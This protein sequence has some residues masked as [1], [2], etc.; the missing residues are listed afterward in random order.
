[1][2]SIGPQLPPHL[3]KRKRS[4]DE[5]SDSDS[6]TDTT[7]RPRAIGPYPRPAPSTGPDDVPLS[8]KRPDPAPPAQDQEEEESSS[9]DDDV[10]PALPP[11]TTSSTANAPHANPQGLQPPPTQSKEPPKREAWMTM[12][13]TSGDWA[14]RPPDPTKLKARKFNSTKPR[15]RGAAAGS[16]TGGEGSWNETP[17]EKAERLRRQVLGG[18][19]PSTGG[20]GSSKA[21]AVNAAFASAEDSAREKAK[22]EEE[23]RAM[24]AHAA[25]RGPSLYTSHQKT[26][27]EEDDDPSA[28]AFN[29]EK[30]IGGGMGINATRRNQMLNAAKGFGG[31]FGEARYL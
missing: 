28:R 21:G 20:K 5:A 23:K 3:S 17:E 26:K 30:D 8:P 6:S 16:G 10:G 1:M 24:A 18:T 19:A 22:R 29:R 13:P 27:T 11:S 4:D 15:S 7:K 2:P 31:R 14:S 25:A 9:D 12:A